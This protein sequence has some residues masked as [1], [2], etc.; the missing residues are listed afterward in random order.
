MVGREAAEARLR[1]SLMIHGAHHRSDCQ[2]RSSEEKTLGFL[3]GFIIAIKFL[4][5]ATIQFRCYDASSLTRDHSQIRDVPDSGQYQQVTCR[6]LPQ[7]CSEGHVSVF[8]LTYQY[9]ILSEVPNS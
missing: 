4:N 8:I 6:S 1:R 7:D 5:F 9:Y 2:T 3:A